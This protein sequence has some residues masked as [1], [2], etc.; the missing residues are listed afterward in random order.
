MFVNDAVWIL[1]V[2][3]FILYIMMSMP[4]TGHSRIVN[5]MSSNLYI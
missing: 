1:I 3:K 5:A 4:A 2:N